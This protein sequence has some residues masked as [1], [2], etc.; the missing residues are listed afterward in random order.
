MLS[1]C[2]VLDSFK[3]AMTSL[4]FAPASAKPTVLDQKFVSTPR[5]RVIKCF[6]FKDMFIYSKDWVKQRIIV[7]SPESQLPPLFFSFLV[8]ADFVNPFPRPQLNSPCW[9]VWHCPKLCKT[10]APTLK[11]RHNDHKQIKSWGHIEEK[12]RPQHPRRHTWLLLETFF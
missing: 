7:L 3:H 10:P 9:S 6:F 5:N 4:R 12:C 1:F 8:C 2:S 11:P